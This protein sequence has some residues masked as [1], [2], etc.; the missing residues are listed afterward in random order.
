MDLQPATSQIPV[1]IAEDNQRSHC[2]VGHT[3]CVRALQA[4]SARLWRLW[5]HK[6]PRA[7]ERDAAWKLR[8]A[9]FSSPRQKASSPR[10]FQHSTKHQPANPPP[11]RTPNPA[12]AQ[13]PTGVSSAGALAGPPGGNSRTAQLPPQP[14]LAV[15]HSSRQPQGRGSRRGASCL[16]A[17]GPPGFLTTQR[18]PNT[19]VFC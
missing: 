7:S 6:K 15:R 2:S 1:P 12:E 4:S 3:D 17:R 10:T 13:A 9:D 14:A 18:M 11:P 19:Y 16:P 8:S 5:L